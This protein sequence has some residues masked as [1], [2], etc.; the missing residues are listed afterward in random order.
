MKI[1]RQKTHNYFIGG[2]YFKKELISQL[3]FLII[4][5]LGFTIAFTWR[6][7]IFDTTQW[8]V[9]AITH[10]ENSTGLSVLTSITITLIGLLIILLTSRYLNPKS[11]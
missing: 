6:Q 9:Q 3:R 5:T 2:D 7:T 8:A 4:V 10:I 11:Y 1:I